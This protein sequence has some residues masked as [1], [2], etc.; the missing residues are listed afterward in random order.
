MKLFIYDHCPYCVKAR[1]IFGLKKTPVD[2][3]TLLNDD[4]ETPISM[5]NQKMVPILE[6]SPGQYMPESMD[7]IKYIDHTFLPTMVI[8]K[9]DD[10]LLKLLDTVH[11][12]YY[13][14]VMPRWTECGMEEFKTPS[15]KKYFQNK[16]EKMIGDFSVALEN[17]S[18]FKTEIENSLPTI[19]GKLHPEGPWYL[20]RQISWNDFHLFAFLRALSIVKDL[21]FPNTIKKYMDNCSKETGVPL[22]T[23][24]AI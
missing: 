2:L 19:A 15:A 17:T 21:S 22:N 8:E 14:L 5:I 9:E 20:G 11:M 23:A 4:E 3:V 13:S 10:S 1:M 18:T 12:S 24:Q 16:K 6:K 7:I